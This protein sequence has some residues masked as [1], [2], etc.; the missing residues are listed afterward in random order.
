MAWGLKLLATFPTFCAGVTCSLVSANKEYLLKKLESILPPPAVQQVTTS[1]QPQSHQELIREIIREKDY[2][3]CGILNGFRGSRAI[4]YICS[5]KGDSNKPALY[6]YDKS[7]D[8]ESRILQ[9][10][11]ISS[12]SR[13]VTFVKGSPERLKYS[14][15]WMH[16]FKGKN[17]N[18]EQDCKFE[19]G[20]G[21]SSYE[22]KCH[23]QVIQQGIQF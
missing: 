6:N 19:K 12:T 10:V 18:T 4:W 21:R 11:S 23:D 14:P 15:Y 7:R 17:L 16:R 22:L 9:V 5:S 13:E 8:L 1:S 3:G 2:E 20:I